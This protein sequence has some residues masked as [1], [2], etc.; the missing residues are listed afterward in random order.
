MPLN[1]V[2]Y[3]TP[4]AKAAGEESDLL[5]TTLRSIGDAVLA[6]DADGLVRFLNPVAEK[7]TGWTEREALGRGSDEV[8][9][10]FNEET[11][12]VVESPVAKV[13][14]EGAVVGLANH[15]VLIARDGVERPIDD[16][17]APVRDGN[18]ELVGAV[19]VFRDITERRRA[20]VET[21][22]LA[23]IVQ[24]SEDAIYTKT[25]Q[26]TVTSWNPAA[27]RMYGYSAGEMVGRS[28]SMLVPPDRP[29][30]L[31]G[32]LSKLATGERIRHYETERI[33]KAGRRMFISKSISPLR[34]SRGE[35]IGAS[36]IAR[37]VTESILQKREIDA[38]NKR[39]QRGMRETHHRIKNSLQMIAALVSVQ[40]WEHGDL[41]PAAALDRV[42]HH[43]AGLAAIHDLLT[44]TAKEGPA[45]PALSVSAV[46]DKLVPML[47]AM[48]SDRQI[49]MEVEDA[50][51]PVQHVTALAILVN[52][53]VSNAVKHG[54][55]TITLV[56]HASDHAASLEVLDE[57]PGFPDAARA[58]AAS[59][60]GME[61]IRT[62][63]KWDMAGTVTFENR[64]E[65]GARVVVQFPWPRMDV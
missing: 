22:H 23:A 7:L 55:G 25:L 61:L 17:G 51:L 15:T 35:I 10:I 49:V 13:L 34:N 48:L 8:F 43:V 45:A 41:V 5:R 53:L 1:R 6:T 52:E 57:G 65:G 46:F 28:V 2:D 59:T 42:S 29:N 16:S 56:F 44:L 14:R 37:D 60:T 58:E 47:R 19:V 3:D 32:L 54:G 26:G 4:D 39:L 50:L 12:A 40:R 64:T 38:L 30:E 33:S 63:T 36:S 31:P 18:G 27:E 20:E 21:A 62:V 11:R 9:R 24:S